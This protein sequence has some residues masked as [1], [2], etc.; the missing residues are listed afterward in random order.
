MSKQPFS[1]SDIG[2]LLKGR[3]LLLITA[4]SC[5][6]G[7]LGH[8]ITNV[9]GSSDYYLGGF[10]SYANVTKEL[11][12]GVKSETLES[13]GAVSKETVSEMAVGA[14]MAL[15]SHYPLERIVALSTSGVAGPGGG[16]VE[17]PVGTVCIAFSTPDKTDACQFHFNGTREEIK[18]QTALQALKI[19]KEYLSN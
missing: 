16:S 14:R 8:M 7:L 3:N 17:K 11:V 6:G 9:P 5:S 10:I 2:T 1:F 12:L 15:K 13:F 18:L 19:L 4:E